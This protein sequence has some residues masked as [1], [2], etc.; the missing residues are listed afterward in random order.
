MEA[1]IIGVDCAT[2]RK[3]VGFALGQ[4]EG[5]DAWIEEVR[6]GSRVPSVAET[7]AGW[8]GGR[9]CTLLALDAPLGW[10]ADLGRTLAAHKAGEPITV[11]RNDL[12]G[13]ETDRF[14]YREVK[15]RPLE[16]GANW[17]AR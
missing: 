4:V 10:P 1:T 2:D 13:R 14:V 15:Q 7:I 6:L 3:R 16:V 11:P 12:F 8:A 9:G 17:I 5:E